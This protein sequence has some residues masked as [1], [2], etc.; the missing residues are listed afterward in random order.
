M[1]C[2]HRRVVAVEA[3]RIQPEVTCSSHVDGV[4]SDKAAIS[5]H[6]RK[7]EAAR[8]ILLLEFAMRYQYK[9]KR[10]SRQSLA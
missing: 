5:T 7:Q 8:N 10:H 4:A 3:V 1:I 2:Q 9:E 6:T